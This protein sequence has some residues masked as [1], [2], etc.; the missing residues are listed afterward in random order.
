MK[1]DSVA[2]HNQLIAMDMSDW[3]WPVAHRALKSGIQPAEIRGATREFQESGAFSGTI[4]DISTRLYPPE[5]GHSPIT[6]VPWDS[7]SQ[8]GI[9]RSNTD[10]IDT[11]HIV[12][13]GQTS[14]IGVD[15]HQYPVRGGV[16]RAAAKMWL[17]TREDL[18]DAEFP[19][20]DVDVFA[21]RRSGM[22]HKP[23][24]ISIQDICYV[25]SLEPDTLVCTPDVTMN[26]VVLD[27]DGLYI[28]DQAIDD[29]RE[30]IIRPID[31]RYTASHLFTPNAVCTT[32]GTLIPTPRGVGRILHY[33]LSHKAESSEFKLPQGFDIGKNLITVVR[34]HI[35]RPDASHRMAKLQ[36]YL[37]TLTGQDQDLLSRLESI[38]N[39]T[40]YLNLTFNPDTKDIHLWLMRKLYEQKDSSTWGKTI[41]D[42]P[43]TNVALNYIPDSVIT[44][45]DSREVDKIKEVFKQ[46]SH[47]R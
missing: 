4:F 44:P 3:F 6:S 33:L 17:K 22:Q 26:Q 9:R 21:H 24:G 23:P 31:S 7:L 13:K 35:A 8:H 19:A 11:I 15:L 42:G 2:L 25:D 41:L 1:P 36:R 14:S 34:K 29:I 43:L 18:I 5:L 30:G 38:R 16:A 32:D 10:G 39:S 47:P 20:N 28:A 27:S 40:P 37:L 45:V 12:R 46:P